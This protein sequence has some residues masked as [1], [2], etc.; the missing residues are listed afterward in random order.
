MSVFANYSRYYDLLYKDKDYRGEAK[1]V[2]DLLVTHTPNAKSILELG[3]GTGIHAK[4][5]AE[6]GYEIHGVDLSESM[7]KIANQNLTSLD[8]ALASRLKFSQGDMRNVR[9]DRTFDVVISLFH[10]ISYQTSNKDLEDAIITAKT[11]LKPGGIFLFDCWYGP[12]VLSDRPVV[13]VKRLEDERIIVTRIAE[14][15]IYANDNLVDVNYQVFI[16]DKYTQAV[17]ELQETHKMRYLFKPELE[18]ILEK[19]KIKLLNFGEWMTGKPSGFNTWG[20]YF[21]CRLVANC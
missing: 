9:V 5:L 3:C 6:L 11:H 18:Y 13:R 12:T 17:E 4:L 2:S 7:L 21:V 1:F 10:V 14:P 16:K 20:S 19:N 15:V 8:P